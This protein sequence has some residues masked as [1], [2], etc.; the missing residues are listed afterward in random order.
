MARTDSRRYSANSTDPDHAWSFGSQTAPVRASPFVSSY[1]SSTVYSCAISRAFESD[2][3]CCCIKMVAENAMQNSFIDNAEDGRTNLS[4]LDGL[5]SV[6][7]THPHHM[8]KPLR[9]ESS[10]HASLENL[11]HRRRFCLFFWSSGS[12]MPTTL[13]SSPS[14]LIVPALG[15][16]VAGNFFCRIQYDCRWP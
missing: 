6:E 16:L 10:D 9:N 4:N 11:N 5:P 3:T 7:E 2:R 8:K 14:A 13:P 1:A 15:F 12:S